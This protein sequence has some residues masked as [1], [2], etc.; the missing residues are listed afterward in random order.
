MVLNP[1]QQK[2]STVVLEAPYHYCGFCTEINTDTGAGSIIRRESKLKVD[3][4]DLRGVINTSNLVTFL[5]HHE[6]HPNGCLD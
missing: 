2:C 1:E 3:R 5:G 4:L 6:V